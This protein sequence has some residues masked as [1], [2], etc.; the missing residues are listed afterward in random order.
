MNVGIEIIHVHHFVGIYVCEQILLFKTEAVYL[1]LK[2]P[3]LKH[4][5]Y[6]LQPI[7]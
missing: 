1:K 3:F 2:L 4:D 7:A 6:A 5:I